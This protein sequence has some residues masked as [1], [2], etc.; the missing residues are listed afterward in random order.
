MLVNRDN[1]YMSPI[2]E[3][4]RVRVELYDVFKQIVSVFKQ[5][6][7]ASLKKLTDI[8]VTFNPIQY[9]AR[10][11]SH[12]SPVLVALYQGDVDYDMVDSRFPIPEKKI[13][14]L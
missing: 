2:N 9:A 8:A 14:L 3:W 6:R 7:P 4:G 12:N 5:L 1:W 13:L 11:L 10:T